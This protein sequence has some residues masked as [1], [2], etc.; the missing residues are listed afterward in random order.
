M[1][2]NSRKIDVKQIEGREK[3]KKNKEKTEVMEKQQEERIV[4]KSIKTK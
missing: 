3:E 4:S 2:T 1:E